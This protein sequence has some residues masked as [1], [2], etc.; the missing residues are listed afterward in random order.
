VGP[1]VAWEVPVCQLVECGN[2]PDVGKL[3][4]NA[5]RWGA[6]VLLSPR[7]T[8]RSRGR[9]D[10]E[11]SSH[12]AGERGDLSA[13]EE[14][15][16]L[17]GARQGSSRNTGSLSARFNFAFWKKE[18]EHEENLED[19]VLQEFEHVEELRRNRDHRLW[20]RWGFA[21][22]H[23][24]DEAS[25]TT[26]AGVIPKSTQLK[27]ASRHGVLKSAQ[28]RSV[29]LS[30]AGIDQN[31]KRYSNL[32]TMYK[33]LLSKKM[34]ECPGCKALNL[35]HISTFGAR[36]LKGGGCLWNENLFS[37]H[38]LSAE[39]VRCAKRILLVLDSK[40]NIEYAPQLPDLVC[41]L[42]LY[43]TEEETF[44][45]ANSFLEHSR[46]AKKWGKEMTGDN[47]AVFVPV[48]KTNSRVF[49]RTFVNLFESQLPIL[50][51]N[52]KELVRDTE[53]LE[54]LFLNWFERFF[55]GVFPLRYV[56]RIFD[57]L[58]LEG[59]KVLYRI[60]LTLL[61]NF[62]AHA[63]AVCAQRKRGEVSLV[64]LFEQC[65]RDIGAI[66][67]SRQIRVKS[68]HAVKSAQKSSDF[69]KS[70]NANKKAS[71]RKSTHLEHL[72][73]LG[74]EFVD[75]YI[76][77]DDVES[78]EGDDEDTSS[79]VSAAPSNCLLLPRNKP[80]RNDH[81]AFSDFFSGS[82]QLLVKKHSER[83]IRNDRGSDFEENSPFSPRFLKSGDLPEVHIEDIASNR[84]AANEL[85]ICRSR[86]QLS[87][88]SDVLCD[89][90]NVI[91]IERKYGDKRFYSESSLL[92][93][94]S[95]AGAAM[96]EKMI[97]SGPQ[98]HGI[99][100][101][102]DG[103]FEFKVFLASAYAWKNLKRKTL[104]K[105]DEM[106]RTKVRAEIDLFT[107]LRAPQLHFSP[108]FLVDSS[109]IKDVSM[110]TKLISW[111]PPKAANKARKLKM[112][113]STNVHGRS[114]AS[115]YEACAKR[116]RKYVTGMLLVMD[117]IPQKD[118]SGSRTIIGAF[119]TKPFH[120]ENGKHGA[121]TN[122]FGSDDC[123]VFR[124]SPGLKARVWK[125]DVA[126]F[127]TSVNHSSEATISTYQRLRSLTSETASSS[128]VSVSSFN[129]L[130]TP[131]STP[132]NN[133]IDPSFLVAQHFF[134]LDMRKEE[135]AKSR[136]VTCKMKS[137]E[138]GSVSSTFVQGTSAKRVPIEDLE[139][140][141]FAELREMN[142]TETL[143]GPGLA[144]DEYLD[145]GRTGWCSTYENNPLCLSGDV[146]ESLSSPMMSAFKIGTVEVF[147]L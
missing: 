15:K 35:E 62:H 83:S 39:G 5:L 114:L 146:I 18:G 19:G 122:D 89:A 3:E 4:M 96:M 38:V 55:V 103:S 124:I 108:Q 84:D 2:L 95:V 112:L 125:P 69:E 120:P 23:K 119:S 12:F 1:S 88:M 59:P 64:E 78:L 43:L 102:K 133:T 127:R 65:Q 6:R 66:P 17:E 144:L 121:S 51:R 117:C 74:D 50:F 115:L 54:S 42:L 80:Q 82:K 126:N 118:L 109:L 77:N 68:A 40:W 36:F 99:A 10:E 123:L 53:E 92:R 128:S 33:L 76:D 58:M 57:C 70:P 48:G 30:M 134:D 142:I 61:K 9:S 37:R 32:I 11:E 97:G 67:D 27:N 21:K 71:R 13:V 145:I 75:K 44:A 143:A 29:W 132:I 107:S 46:E 131:I 79:E 28:R 91:V 129:S 116:D 139:E 60:A 111:L 7:S 94:S 63:L 8:K 140:L 137:L 87:S 147:Q 138:F 34:D 72:F 52:I 85:T 135:M 31:S 14:Q 26:K 113:F 100:S 16:S 136:F 24:G 45:V 106:N 104:N 41:I 101:K 25:W 81:S 93:S 141:T 110:A 73:N 90:N 49:V 86:P 20:A 47:V 56:I 130:Q 22:E 105:L 98:V